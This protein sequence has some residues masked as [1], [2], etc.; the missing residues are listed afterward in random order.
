MWFWTTIQVAFA[1]GLATTFDDN[2][3]LT[4]FF[5]EVN[6]SF[7]PLHVVAGEII[8]F[9]VL[10]SLSLTGYAVGMNLPSKTVGLLGILP[11]IIG[12]KN[13][14]EFA[15]EASK[16]DRSAEKQTKSKPES[17]RP[18]Y[19]TGFKA[20]KLTVWQVLRDQKTYDVALVSI[21]NGSNN[22][23][24]YIPLFAS[25]TLAKIAV[26]IPVLYLFIFT[27]LALSFTL[28]RMPGIS[29][30]LNR[31]SKIFFPFILIWLGYRILSDSGAIH[32]WK[33][34]G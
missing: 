4:A 20:R 29:L 16:F 32:L 3:Y 19:L 13:L 30:V 15:N 17:I 21:S 31:Y 34:Q 2:I 23:S 9:T 18:H 12:I 5:G 14:I 1:A 33:F 6:R 27:W 11:I 28:T 24:I 7:R 22:L 25:L 10:L 26:V 8:G